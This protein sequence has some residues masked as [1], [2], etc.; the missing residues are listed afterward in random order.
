METFSIQ[1]DLRKM[2]HYSK[3]GK[4]ANMEIVSQLRAPRN[5]HANYIYLEMWAVAIEQYWKLPGLL[6]QNN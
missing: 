5:I 2:K 3:N 4:C 1:Q 6:I